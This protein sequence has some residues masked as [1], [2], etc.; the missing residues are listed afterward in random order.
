M[1]ARKISIKGGFCED[2]CDLEYLISLAALL[3]FGTKC[4]FILQHFFC[5]Q[6]APFHSDRHTSAHHMTWFHVHVPNRRASLAAAGFKRIGSSE[7]V[8]PH[9][10]PEINVEHSE[11]EFYKENKNGGSLAHLPALVAFILLLPS[12][13]LPPPSGPTE[14]R[15]FFPFLSSSPHRFLSVFVICRADIFLPPSLLPHVSVTYH[16]SEV[17]HPFSTAVTLII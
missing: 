14:S 1:N 11:K 8:I 15:T 12:P 9:W 3:W 2:K 6:T 17:F 5:L 16:I 13:R 7:S 4:G 10:A